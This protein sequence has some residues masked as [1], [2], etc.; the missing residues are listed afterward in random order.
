MLIRYKDIL[1]VITSGRDT[2]IKSKFTKHVASL[3]YHIRSLDL[4]LE[5]FSHP[6]TQTVRIKLGLENFQFRLS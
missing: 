4:D 1:E 2:R 3:I 5:K 6:T